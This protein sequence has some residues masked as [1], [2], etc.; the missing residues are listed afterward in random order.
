[1]KDL[2]FATVLGFQ[3]ASMTSS[4]SLGRPNCARDCPI[5]WLLKVE[6]LETVGELLT[7]WMVGKAFLNL[8][9]AEW[10]IYQM[11][12]HCWKPVLCCPLGIIMIP[13]V[14]S[15]ISFDM[16]A[17]ARLKGRNAYILWVL[18]L[19]LKAFT[20]M[21]YGPDIQETYLSICLLR[22]VGEHPFCVVTED[23]RH[24]VCHCVLYTRNVTWRNPKTSV[25]CK[26]P[27]TFCNII[28]NNRMHA[29]HIVNVC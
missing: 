8:K 13:M 20:A 10:V 7:V 29:S 17:P 25:L 27:Y 12:E 16:A 15:L 23:S 11:G 6:A 18:Q 3:A 28:T 22:R 9:G 26:F 19:K 14:L 2:Y 4:I 21:Q 1:M 24:F 5:G